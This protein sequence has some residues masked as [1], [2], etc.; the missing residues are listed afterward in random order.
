M[1][2]T[3]ISLALLGATLLS[4]AVTQLQADVFSDLPKDENGWSTT[5]WIG[6]V[7]D[8]TANDNWIYQDNLGWIYYQGDADGMWFW[9][10]EYGWLWTES[11]AYPVIWS[12]NE[13]DW[14]LHDTSGDFQKAW[15]WS[16]RQETWLQELTTLFRDAV[17]VSDLPDPVE[18]DSSTMGPQGG[19]LTIDTGE[20][21]GVTLDVPAGALP[22]ERTITLGYIDADIRPNVGTASGRIISIDA[23]G[24]THFEEPLAVTIPFNAEQ[25][26]IAVPYYVDEGGLLQACQVVDVDEANGTLTYETFHASVF[27]DFLVSLYDLIFGQ[28]YQPG[29]NGFQVVNTG[30]SY[31]PGGECF[32]MAAFAQWY[33]RHDHGDLY[34]SYMGTYSGDGN[35]S[36]RGQNIIATRAHTALTQKWSSY[37]PRVQ[38]TAALS[39]QQLYATITNVIA[40]TDAPT[41]LYLARPGA[42]HAVLAYDFDADGKVYIN[43]PNVPGAANFITYNDSTHV[44]TNY[45]SYTTTG[46]IGSGSFTYESF[47]NIYQ[48]AEDNFSGSGLAQVAIINYTDGDT[49]TDRN[50]TLTGN[51]QSGQALI[52][53][54]TVM[55]NGTVA[56]STGVDQNGDFTVAVNLVEGLNELTF[57]TEAKDSNGNLLERPNTQIAPFELNLD[58]LESVILVTLTWTTDQTDV[59]LYVTDPTGDTS[60]YS[61]KTTADGGELDFDDTDG[62]GPE[63]WTLAT[64]DTVRWGEPYNVRLHYYSAHDTGLSA[65]Y[66]VTVN[67]Y[68]GSDRVETYNYSGTLTVDSSSND[69]PG[70]TGSDWVTIGSFTPVQATSP[71][72]ATSD[73][74]APQSA[75]AIAHPQFLEVVDPAAKA[76]KDAWQS[77]E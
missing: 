74:T 29:V 66:R 23:D 60:W 33:Y 50:I 44:L 63:H 43:D 45:Q 59:D 76:R 19:S 24:L 75:T 73:A 4:S 57:K 70:S 10:P 25:D 8:D 5:G 58:T 30:S 55:L 15:F 36:V 3:R 32:G 9:R 67:L 27:T 26:I 37:V 2:T 56:Y 12:W 61:D 17:Q 53:K 7:W 6:W 54:L 38:Q 18:V 62:Y 68:E 1:L 13:N 49:V 65:P 52:E 69:A 14:V 40:N 46:H 20:L 64:T 11:G 35:Q 77:A 72:A 16:Y 21:A 47:Q 42:A 28:D 34:H 31:N 41:I 48:D 39:D 51:I 22:D 71:N